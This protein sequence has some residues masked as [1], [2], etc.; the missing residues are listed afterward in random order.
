M[1][2]GKSVFNYIMEI[3]LN[4]QQLEWHEFVNNFHLL[5]FI[6]TI[7]KGSY[8]KVDKYYYKKNKQF[9]VAKQRIFSNNQRSLT[10][11]LP[12]DVIREITI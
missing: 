12:S 8:G 1:H 4:Y 5:E 7:G 9:V 2:S 10:I 6:E 11:G 3:P